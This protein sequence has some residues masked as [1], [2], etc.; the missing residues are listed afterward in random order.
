MFEY[1]QTQCFQ[2]GYAELKS[3]LETGVQ[4]EA[5][6]WER[7]EDLEGL[8]EPLLPVSG[9]NENKAEHAGR[10]VCARI[11]ECHRRR[12][13]EDRVIYGTPEPEMELGR[14][15]RSRSPEL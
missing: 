15:N 8:Y 10:V 4:W 13:K 7:F 11:P 3:L 2:R 14:G 12:R 9:V 5:V 1:F 6:T